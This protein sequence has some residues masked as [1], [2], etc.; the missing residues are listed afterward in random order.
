MLINL[1]LSNWDAT[2]FCPCHTWQFQ[3]SRGRSPEG[4]CWE[5]LDPETGLYIRTWR[6]EGAE[7]GV[8]VAESQAYGSGFADLRQ[9]LDYVCGSPVVWRACYMTPYRP[10]RWSYE[11]QVGGG[12]FCEG[13]IHM[14]TC[15]RSLFGVATK[16]QG[17]VRSF[18]GGTGPDS[19]TLLID[20]EGG[21]QLCLQLGWGT[22]DCFAGGSLLPNSVGFFGPRAVLPWAPADDHSAMWDHLLLC[23]AGEAQPVATA[24]HAA[25]AVGDLWRCY[26][27][28]GVV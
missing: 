25:A 3:P 1:R 27:A 8:Y 4:I 26:A 18:A 24:A 12:A 9:R 21:H 22:A 15:A 28:A 20:Y 2:R 14:L 7:P 17:S 19:G 10:Q 11:L 16:W 6:A 23:L 13:G 5:R